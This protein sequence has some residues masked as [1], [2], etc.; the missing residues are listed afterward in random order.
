MSVSA[1]PDPYERR[2]RGGP[3]PSVRRLILLTVVCA[4]AISVADW[5]IG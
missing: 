3:R 5:L 1:I 4:V 2:R